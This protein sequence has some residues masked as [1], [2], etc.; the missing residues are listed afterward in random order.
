MTSQHILVYGDERILY[1]IN[2]DSKRTARI[3]IHVEPDGSVVVDAPPGQ[4]NEMV[5]RG[6]Q[7]RARWISDH[8]A[9]AR[10][11]YR[12]VQP[13]SYISGEQVLYLGRRYVLKVVQSDD[14]RGMARL[15]GNKLEVS[16]RSDDVVKIR[17]IVRAWYQTRAR[18]YFARQISEHSARLPWVLKPPPFRLLEMS[19][20]WGS[21]SPQGQV[22]LN[23]H[24]IKAP[25]DCIEYVIVH[26]LAHLKH[27]DHSPEFFDLVS[28]Y[29]PEWEKPKR[30]LDGMVEVLTND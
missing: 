17:G 13:K 3:G 12:H 19:S 16:T 2:P 14:A 15:R 21:C 7:K 1:Q 28:R 29:S 25:R 10:E 20:Q 30:M 6:V 4:P 22:I 18:S 9:D 24:L 23:P 26:E 11:R 8:V 27:H 5:H